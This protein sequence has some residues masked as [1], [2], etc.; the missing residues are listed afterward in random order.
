[1]NQNYVT[2]YDDDD[3]DINDDFNLSDIYDEDE[4]HIDSEKQDN[5]YYIGLCF[6]EAKYK[7]PILLNISISN[8]LFF[9]YQNEIINDFL[10]YFHTHDNI[11][12]SNQIRIDIMKTNFLKTTPGNFTIYAV[13]LK[14]F[15][16]RLVQRTWRKVYKQKM[17]IVKKRRHIFNLRH[18]EI[19]GK[20]PNGLNYLP[21][22][23]GMMVNNFYCHDPGSN[24]GP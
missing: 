1:M 23:H 9:K 12:N 14:T 20:Y 11:Y 5:S 7:E 4:D 19:H 15:W 16:L 24:Q 3:D 6:R 10:S 13:V 8:K 22:L 21:G 2:I 17:Q 18:R